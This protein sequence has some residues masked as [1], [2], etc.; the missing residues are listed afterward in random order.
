MKLVRFYCSSQIQ[1]SLNLNIFLFNFFIRHVFIIYLNVYFNRIKIHIS[2]FSSTFIHLKI[3]FNY[4]VLT[5]HCLNGSDTTILNSQNK[6][7]CIQL[8]IINRFIF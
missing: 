7:F 2:S 6:T 1:F 4:N 8:I 5:P 3:K